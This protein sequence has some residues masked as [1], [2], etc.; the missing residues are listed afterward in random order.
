MGV[1]QNLDVPMVLARIHSAETY[2]LAST[3]KVPC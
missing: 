2:E 1:L 3:M